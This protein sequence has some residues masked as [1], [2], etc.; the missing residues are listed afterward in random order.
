M[1]ED[2]KLR[3]ELANRF[4]MMRQSQ[5]MRTGKVAGGL[6]NQ[7]EVMA[8]SDDWLDPDTLTKQHLL[9]AGCDLD[10]IESMASEAATLSKK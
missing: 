9:M 8:S 5:N 3:N 10:P 7:V 2:E 4:R 1:S 6:P